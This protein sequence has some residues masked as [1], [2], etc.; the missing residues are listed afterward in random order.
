MLKFL[1]LALLFI[2]AAALADPGVTPNW[3]PFHAYIGTWEGIRTSPTGE[4]PVTRKYETGFESNKLQVV[5]RSGKKEL[6]WGAVTFDPSRGAF[7]LSRSGPDDDPA[8]FL[9][10]KV[11]DDGTSL[12]FLGSPGGSGHVDRIQYVR[13]GWNDFVEI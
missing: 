12:T 4:S 13:H 11:S 5:E 2:P 1:V 10:D 6:P 9:L 8:E 7:V 3:T